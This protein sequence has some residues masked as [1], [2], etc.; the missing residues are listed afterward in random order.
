M[1][2]PELD[3]QIVIV[4]RFFHHYRLK[5]LH[6][7][8]ASIEAAGGRLVFVYSELN[9]VSQENLPPFAVQLDTWLSV[10]L[11]VAGLSDRMMLQK[12]LLAELRRQKPTL[13]IAEDIVSLPSTLAIALYG[14]FTGRPYAIWTLGPHV[15]G[16]RRSY[17]RSLLAVFVHFIR[18]RAA[19]FIAY[20][21][22]GVRNLQHCC[23]TPI[24]PAYNSIRS[25]QTAPGDNDQ[26]AAKYLSD[27]PPTILY[28]GRL[29]F[30]KG[31][32]KLIAAMGTLQNRTWMLHIV[33][34]GEA[35]PSLAAMAAE[36][37][38]SDRIV[39]HGSV[40]DQSKKDD[41]FKQ[42]HLGVMPGLGGLFVQEAYTYGLPVIAGPAD[43]TEFDLIRDVNPS[44]F[45]ESMTAETLAAAVSKF[46]DLPAE[47]KML[48]ATRAMQTA[49]EK[50][51]IENMRDG[52]MSAI[53][54]LERPA[55]V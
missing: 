54:H 25:P 34:D 21:D 13:V 37:K 39:F 20:S 53:T 51:N 26:L 31:V 24:Y 5:F 44:L 42:S 45:V 18:S 17:L 28:V 16:K 23:D 1:V 15:V 22:W 10:P 27:G 32:D 43:G 6:A 14:V 47:D 11:N 29:S 33:G 2:L 38:I 7:L 30:H 3:L 50:Y 35:R 46:L 40:V 8:N 41:F 36:L 4:Q 55:D 48:L 12:G 9:G 52:F 49:K 19:G